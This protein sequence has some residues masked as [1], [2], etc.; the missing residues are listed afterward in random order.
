[1]RV[2]LNEKSRI[3][4]T[5]PIFFSVHCHLTEKVTKP[6]GF[7][8]SPEER[9]PFQKFEKNGSEKGIT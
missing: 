7:R 5:E 1:M 2:A 4:T 9:A 8:L 3:A 6:V